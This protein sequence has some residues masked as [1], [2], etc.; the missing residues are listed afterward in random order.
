M[1]SIV[2]IIFLGPIGLMFSFTGLYIIFKKGRKEFSEWLSF[3]NSEKEPINQI[4]R[5]DEPVIIEG[6]AQTIPEHGLLNSPLTSEECIAYNYKIERKN[7]NNGWQVI[8]SDSD[9]APFYIKEDDNK[10]YTDPSNA[11]VTIEKENRSQGEINPEKI[12]E[13]SI[14]IG[15]V[16]IPFPS[17]RVKYTEKRIEPSEECTVLGKVENTTEDAI[18]EINKTSNGKFIVSDDEV[19]PTMNRILI[20]GVVFSLFGL[21]FLGVGLRVLVELI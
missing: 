16:E 2:T 17:G 21:L 12:P 7:H 1:V 3:R 6:T 10:V 20:R 4:A 14:T 15:S 8:E 13:D 5:G 11:S 9:S 18:Y 19:S